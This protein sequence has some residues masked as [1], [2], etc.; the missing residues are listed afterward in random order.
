[1]LMSIIKLILRRRFP[2]RH[3]GFQDQDFHRED[4]RVFLPPKAEG[5]SQL[6]GQGEDDL[7][8]RSSLGPEDGGRRDR[9]GRQKDDQTPI[10]GL[11][12][13]YDSIQRS[14]P[15]LRVDNRV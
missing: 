11:W 13:L 8:W 10:C 3:G 6:E 7:P 15:P 2:H 5:V 9:R 4:W 1:M 14:C 12:D